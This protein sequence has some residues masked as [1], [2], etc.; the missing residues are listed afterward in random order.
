[1]IRYLEPTVG[2]QVARSRD[3]AVPGEVSVIGYDD[4][5]LMAFTDPPRTT[6][7]SSVLAM[8]MA[9]AAALVDEIAGRVASHPPSM[10]PP[11]THN[12]G[13]DRQ[14]RDRR[15]AHGTIGPA[16]VGCRSA[17]TAPI[18]L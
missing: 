3:L 14:T 7:R 13:P 15:P 16:P 6:V 8:G 4:S 5:M 11:P 18:S 12:N 17:S 10:A 9:A 2:A 1:M